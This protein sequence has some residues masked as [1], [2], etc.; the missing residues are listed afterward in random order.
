MP[1]VSESGVGCPLRS[2]IWYKEAQRGTKKARGTKRHKE[3]NNEAQR[4]TKRHKERER[5]E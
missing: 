4:G 2:H 3:A 5:E 1:D